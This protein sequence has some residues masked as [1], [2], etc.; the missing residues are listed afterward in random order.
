MAISKK[1]VRDVDLKGKRV[2]MRVDFNVPMKDGVVQD[3]TRLRAA[4]P[5]VNYILNQG[6]KSLVLMSHLGDPD[7][8]IPK[9]REKAAKDGKPFDEK[10]F[11]EG[12]FRMAPV[13]RRFAELLGREVQFAPSCTGKETAAMVNALSSG[14]VLMLE[15][16]RFHK[17]ETSKDAAARESFAKELTAYGDV[18]VND[19]FGSAHRAHASTETVARFLPAVAGLL[20]EKELEYL[21]DKVV[22]APAKPFAAILGGAKVSSKITVIEALLEKV[23][24]LIIGGAM[25]NTFLKAQGLETGKSLVE[26]DQL[27]T[28]RT[29]INKAGSKNVSLL[30]PLDM[31][32]GTEFSENAETRTVDCDSIPPDT[33]GM[34]IGPRTVEKI[35]E[36]L[37]GARTIFWNGPMG[38]FEMKK[39]S[40][41]TMEVAGILAD[42]KG[43]VTVIGGGDTVSAVNKAGVSE[44]M[45][46]ISTGGGASLKLVEGKTLPG[47]SALLNK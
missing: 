3:D 1:T 5:T 2:L 18:Y 7:K 23:N 16:T 30:L 43:A 32:V 39:F 9:A 34:D 28:A 19:A 6:A 13:A 26:E 47:I 29:I 8:D 17:G 10:K 40:K 24:C 15:N 25:A 33:Q 11:S 46:H 44:K 14:Q 12:K 45:T 41:G 4:L 20:M 38:V 27:D 35:K 31:V 36:A 22:K 21:E 42:L 37:S